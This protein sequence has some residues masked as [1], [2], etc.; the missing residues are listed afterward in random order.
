MKKLSNVSLFFLLTIIFFGCKKNEDAPTVLPVTPSPTISST[1]TVSGIIGGP[2]NTV[3]TL[4]GTNFTSDLSKIKVTVNDKVCT[5]LSASVDSIKFQVPA[6]C[7]RGNILLEINGIKITGPIFEYVYTY[8]LSSVT[9]GI[10]GYQDG[11]LATSTWNQI[12]GLCVDTSDN[13]YTS[14]Y[15]LPI[16]RKITSDYSTASTLAGNGT[17]GN[18]NAQGTNARLGYN[19]N[20]SVDKNG[21]IY[22]ADQVSSSVKKID[23]LGNVTT[24]IAAPVVSPITAFVSKQ[25]NVFVLSN[26]GIAKYNSTGGFVWKVVS[27]GIGNVSGDSSVVKFNYITWGNPAIDDAEQNLYF[28]DYNDAITNTPS[29][30]KKLNLQTLVTSTVAGV[31][32]VGGS[33]DGSASTA[34]FKTVCGLV[35]DK[36]GGMYIGDWNGHRIRYLINGTVSTIIGAAG[37]GDVDGLAANAKIRTPNGLALNKQGDLIISCSGNNKVKRLII[38]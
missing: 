4:K 1:T 11:P 13:I 29:Q 35:I 31:A 37:P 18:V 17:I 14:A 8:T 33:M 16:V 20:I 30:I 2:K 28:A 9:N 21:N 22:Y 34:T 19:D 7:G 15:S 24:F 26:D 10:V 5:I 32:N 23:R 12:Q 3:V 25:G 36:F 38:D 6:Y 27:H